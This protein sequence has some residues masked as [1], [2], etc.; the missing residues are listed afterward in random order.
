M[1]K[2]GGGLKKRIS[3]KTKADVRASTLVRKFLFTPR[4]TQKMLPESSSNQLPLLLSS[5]SA[6]I[7]YP[8]RKLLCGCEKSG[9]TTHYCSYNGQFLK[10]QP[11]C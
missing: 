4:I 2:G 9:N 3:S 1:G 5:Q 6:R 7:H 8:T 10:V 11:S